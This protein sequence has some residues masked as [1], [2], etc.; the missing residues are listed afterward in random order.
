MSALVRSILSAMLLVSLGACSL[1]PKHV[2]PDAPVPAKV[3][4]GS[5]ESVDGL[6]MYG[7]GIKEF[8]RDPRLQEL[9]A[10]GLSHNRDLRVALLAAAR[11]RA[12]YSVE[13]AERFPQVSA[14]GAD[15]SSAPYDKRWTRNVQAQGTAIFELDLFGR[16]RNLSESAFETYLASDEAS[17]A[18]MLALISQIARS[19]LDERLAVERLALAR[20][21]V[22][23]RR[24]SL[25][26][27]AGRVQ[28]GQS[29]LL[30]LEQA[31]SLLAAAEASS[32][33]QQRQ[34]E[35]AGNALALQVGDY[36]LPDLPAPLSLEDQEMA[37]L[38]GGVDSSVLLR[39][40]DIL[41]AEHRLKATNADIGA[42]RAA[43]FPTLS[44]TGTLGYMSTDLSDLF[45]YANG[46]WS[47][48]PRAALPIFQGG[49]QMAELKAAHIAKESAVADYERTIQNAF[50]EVADG[51][52]SRAS[53]RDQHEAQLAYVQSLR[54]V[55]ELAM[56][57]YVSGA[58]SYLEVLDAQRAV[59]Q[60]E[61]DLLSLRRDQLANE[62]SLYSS[63]GGGLEDAVSRVPEPDGRTPSKAETTGGDGE[64]S[65]AD[66][67]SP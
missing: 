38:P 10:L 60:A 19:Y 16:L 1:A 15:T 53:F 42:A 13:R 44:L 18:A 61:M 9:I 34:V 39:R 45:I 55:E 25:E 33:E 14:D 3:V 50:K 5:E 43:F 63:L 31:R 37:N 23:S 27:M 59:F 35:L 4:A 6:G 41:G 52:R 36:D 46:A 48:A 20:S 26:F 12:L 58:V 49:R 7:V 32:A 65:G 54:L 17:R 66:V 29:S 64:P 8:F 11:A 24:R 51:L 22:E 67:V 57:R 62:V 30:E 40:P 2:R 28:S 21:T 47:F 56:A